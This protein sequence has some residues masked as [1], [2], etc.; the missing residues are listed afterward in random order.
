MNLE[1]RVERLE[2]SVKFWKYASASSLIVL[3]VAYLAGAN[4]VSDTIE[5][6]KFVVYGSKGYPAFT[7]TTNE[8]GGGIL[9]LADKEGKPLLGAS[10]I[11]NRELL[12]FDQ[13]GRLAV[14]LSAS[15]K[16]GGQIYTYGDNEKVSSAIGSSDKSGF[17][18]FYDRSGK[19]V[20]FVP[21]LKG[22]PSNDVVQ[23]SR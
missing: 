13:E 17:M 16:H 8:D 19:P 23:P 9:L 4:S 18:M 21:N 1:K 5:A 7:A 15:E 2:R 14:R 3:T 6:K 22:Q 12:L 20:D 10:N 11:K